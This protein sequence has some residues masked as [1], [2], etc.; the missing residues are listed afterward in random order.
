MGAVGRFVFRKEMCLVRESMCG[1]GRLE[2]KGDSEHLNEAETKETQDLLRCIGDC[3]LLVW[4]LCSLLALRPC[5]PK[6]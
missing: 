4:K 1:K 3:V 2:V 6:V 5:L